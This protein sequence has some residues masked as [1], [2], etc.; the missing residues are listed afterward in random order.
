MD[1]NMEEAVKQR[2]QALAAAMRNNE[3]VVVTPTGEVAFDEELQDSP[4]NTAIQVPEG[5]LA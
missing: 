4:F 3:P 1:E 2:R 5:K